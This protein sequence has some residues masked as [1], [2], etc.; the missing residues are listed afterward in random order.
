[1]I[2]TACAGAP[3]HTALPSSI[4][5]AHRSIGLTLT[6]SVVRVKSFLFAEPL[7]LKMDGVEGDENRVCM[8]SVESVVSYAL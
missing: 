3:G 6:S 7:P 5:A 2:A 1:M 8:Y 4:S